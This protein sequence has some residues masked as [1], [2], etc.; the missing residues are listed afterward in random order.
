MNADSMPNQMTRKW[1][2]VP[3]L[4]DWTKGQYG[5]C[6]TKYVAPAS[7][8]DREERSTSMNIQE[9]DK[10][11]YNQV[12]VWGIESEAREKQAV[13]KT[14]LESRNHTYSSFCVQHLT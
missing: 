14:E 2:L 9:L 11:N 4:Q 13:A 10:A 3:L 7:K 8:L 12:L 1:A 5:E 6:K